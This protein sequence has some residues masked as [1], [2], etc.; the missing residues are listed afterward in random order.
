MS[1][2]NNDLFA[3]LVVTRKSELTGWF[4]RGSQ[5]DTDPNE[6][7]TVHCHAQ[8]S[9]CIIPISLHFRIELTWTGQWTLSKPQEAE[10]HKPENIIQL[11]CPK[12]M[13]YSLC[14]KLFG[15]E[16]FIKMLY[17]EHGAKTSLLHCMGVVQMVMFITT[18]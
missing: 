17:G 10:V 15:K 5:D 2:Y 14:T 8:L 9:R 7:T 16:N 6:F 11:Q 4:P 18:D 3:R 1:K 12:V 13:E